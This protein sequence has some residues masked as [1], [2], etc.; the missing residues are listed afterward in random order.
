MVEAAGDYQVVVVAVAVVAL[1]YSI[2]VEMAS[3]R[4]DIASY[5]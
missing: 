4:V 1:Q 3:R 2:K 5:P